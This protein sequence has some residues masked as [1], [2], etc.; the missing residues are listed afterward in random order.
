MP[1]LLV[2][3]VTA[4]IALSAA[5]PAHA[6][7]VRCGT[8]Q[9]N[10]GGAAP[11]IKRLRA[12]N[13]PPRTD[14]YASPCLVAGAAAL[15]IRARRRAGEREPGRI[16]VHGASWDGGFYRCTYTRGGAARVTS[17]RCRRVDK[18]WRRVTM[19]LAPRAS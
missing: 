16:E 11:A 12:V 7:S 10:E 8:A 18:P 2:L 3:A 17:V 15:E 13:Q 6:D 9:L 4:A 1:R 14:Y 19:R 5:A